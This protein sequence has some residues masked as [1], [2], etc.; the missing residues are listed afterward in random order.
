M[1]SPTIPVYHEFFL[2]TLRAVDDLGGSGSISEIVDA[3][4]KAQG[5]T[6]EQHAVLHKNGPD[7]EIGY[8][9]AWARTYLKYFG[10]LSNSERGVWAIRGRASCM[11]PRPRT[12]SVIG[13]CRS[14]ARRT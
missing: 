8:R 5:Y 4:I 10:L 9:L 6:E 2:P 11:T 12:N 7:T 14:S 13:N 3:V 1:T